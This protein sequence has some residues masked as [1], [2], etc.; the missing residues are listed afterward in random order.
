MPLRLLRLAACL[1]LALAL[2]AHGQVLV[3]QMRTDLP[4]LSRLAPH[5]VAPGQ[6]VELTLSGERL[7]GVTGILSGASIELAEVLE[8]AGKQ[9]RLRVRIPAEAPRGIF[10]FHVLCKSGLSN[11]RLLR[12]DD[13][14]IITEQEENRRASPQAV[15]VPCGICGLLTAADEDFFRFEV[16]AERQLVFDLEAQRLG[17]PLRGV[18][19]LADSQGRELVKVF[20]PGSD[21]TGDARLVHRLAPGSYLL[22]VSER[23]FTGA[24]FSAYYLRVGELPMAAAM[25]PLGGQRG[26]KVPVTLSGGSLADPLVHE[27]DLAGDLPATRMR[28]AASTPTGSVLFPCLFAVG[29][30]PEV[31][32]AEPNGTP[33][34]AQAV[35][36]PLTINGRID[37]PRDVDVFR[38][39]AK[40]GSKLLLRV[41]A[42][43]LGSPVDSVL[44]IR[45]A[46]EKELATADDAPAADRQPPVV[47]PAVVLQTID[48]AQ[49][50]FTAPADG[51]F[52]VTIEDRYAQ[53]GPLHAYR[54]EMAPPR[55]DFE[56]LV[57]PGQSTAAQQNQNNNNQQGQVLPNF[58]GQG[59]GALSL[60]RGGR[61]SL[62]VRAIR[63][64]YAGP[65]DLELHGLPSDVAAG[66]A[67]IAA[68][69]NEI[70]LTLSAGFDAPSTASF[71][72]IVGRAQAENFSLA[73]QA[74]QPVVLGAL[75]QAGVA[76]QEWD[77]VA[78]G[79][80]GQG[81]ELAL[82]GELAGPLAPGGQT[83]L[84]LIVRRREGYSGDVAVR[85]L[86]PSSSLQ[87]GQVTIPAA[88]NEAQLDLAAKVDLEPGRRTLQLEAQMPSPDKNKKEPITALALVELDVQPLAVVELAAQQ[89]DLPFGGKAS[90]EVRLQSQCPAAIELT[91]VRLPK[92]VTLGSATIPPGEQRFILE[93]TAAEDA[94]P[95][96]IRSIVQLKVTT[97]VGEQTI[98]LPA[99][100]LAVK[101]V[102]AP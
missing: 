94:R 47:R 2:P 76:Q 58:W 26:Q 78:V 55:P 86:N 91:P 74:V 93:L 72:R 29:E 39:Q 92:G 38:F 85:A 63:R 31:L 61:G 37:R 73:R 75:P 5:A 25:F 44:T 56:L 95:S 53:G 64:G 8:A 4:A 70:S 102:K 87:V 11:P 21:A 18:L 77:S 42:R 17:S 14:P 36:P 43:Q 83:T 51:E 60:D 50:E 89:L 82:R 97:K 10:P 84:R 3:Q 13:L 7:E 98:E 71:L 12:I 20:G 40:A 65:I 69:Q 67:T 16:T 45:D 24:D 88:Q 68:G 19:T 100:R 35:A 9:A 66:A 32:E 30:F 52:T 62:V 23:T 96:T 27:V 57:Q 81:A 90:V 1:L 28:L 49:V 54:L 59:T 48:D 15:S 22:K 34:Q 101:V 6:E 46:S 33:P 79:V 99:L 41:V 80:S